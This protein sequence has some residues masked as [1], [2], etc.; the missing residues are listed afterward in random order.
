MRMT[1]EQKDLR[2]SLLFE[3][4]AY[5]HLLS[6]SPSPQV[7][8]YAFHI[9]L[10]GYRFSKAG[11]KEHAVRAYRQGFQIYRGR[12]WRVAEEHVLYTLGHQALLMKDYDSTAELFNELLS[13]SRPASANALQ[14]MCH[15]REF[16]IVHHLREKGNDSGKAAASAAELTVPVFRAQQCVADLSCREWGGGE[17][18]GLEGAHP[19]A[20]WQ[21]L[22]KAVCEQMRG[23]EIL[24]LQRT[25]QT[26]FTPVSNNSLVPQV[27]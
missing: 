10:A 26:I 24:F 4:A 14:Q 3:Q 5:C 19:G 1:N 6:T 22:E 16:F 8:K 15:L 11:Q 13:G 12:G 18:L 20:S 7:R 25:C 2:S 17:I 9:I 27:F 23:Q 21:A